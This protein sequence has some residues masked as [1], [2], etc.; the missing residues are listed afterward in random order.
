MIIISSTDNFSVS[1]SVDLRQ[2]MVGYS[3]VLTILLRKTH[4]VETKSTIKEGLVHE[5]VTI[6]SRHCRI[7]QPCEGK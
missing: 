1:L 6:L 7:P 3:K 4:T 2:N 5:D